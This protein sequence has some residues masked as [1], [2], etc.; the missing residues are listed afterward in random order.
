M[1]GTLPAGID[2]LVTQVH[3]RPLAM[4]TLARTLLAPR[5]HGAEARQLCREAIAL[6]PD[7][8]QVAALAATVL[9]RGVGT[10]YFSMVQDHPRHALYEKTLAQII[11]PGSVVLDIGAGTGLFAMMA[12][13]AGAAQ[14]IA[15][16]RDPTVAEAASAVVAANGLADR[17]TI[18]PIASQDLDPADLPRPADI[19][20]WDNLAN[21]LWGAGCA[22]TLRDAQ[23]RLLAP[24][25]AVIP[26]RVEI[27]AAF[28]TDLTPE[29][30]AMGDVAGFDMRAFN[31]VAPNDRTIRNRDF[32][33]VG[34]PVTLFDVDCTRSRFREEQASAV[35]DL[36][37]G[38]TVNGVA[39]WLRFHLGNGL[40]YDTGAASVTAFGAQFH[41]IAPFTLD[42][43]GTVTLGAG[44]DMM[45]VWFWAEPPA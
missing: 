15:C 33:V 31:S 4:V 23:E 7:D 13:R 17:V 1:H 3:G 41:A 34:Q 27:V 43:P 6:A 26:G 32:S 35:V 2:R 44:H 18:L 37:A 12:A 11:K 28:V 45:D 29:D 25:A 14:V 24:G 36:P 30:R 9:A 8:G 21:N 42:K 16:E 40:V 20:L 38:V 5:G 19:L 22:A 39:Q 10:W